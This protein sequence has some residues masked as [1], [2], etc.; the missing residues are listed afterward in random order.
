MKQFDLYVHDMA[1][2]LL[3][4]VQQLDPAL[5]GVDMKILTDNIESGTFKPTLGS[6][7]VTDTTK[8]SS[9]LVFNLTSFCARD[10][11]RDD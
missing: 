1:S 2:T 10:S 4:R 3:Q 6:D 11:N 8:F 5:A 7:S 9:T